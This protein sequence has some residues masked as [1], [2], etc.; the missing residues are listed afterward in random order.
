MRDVGHYAQDAYIINPVLAIQPENENEWWK[1]RQDR[2]IPFLVREIQS[3]RRRVAA[4][5]SK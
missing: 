1:L 3:L 4:L 2:I 5:E